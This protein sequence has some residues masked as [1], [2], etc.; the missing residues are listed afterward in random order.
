MYT[1]IEYLTVLYNNEPVKVL[2]CL[3]SLTKCL[4]NTFVETCMVHVLIEFIK[5]VMSRVEWWKAR[6]SKQLPHIH[7]LVHIHLLFHIH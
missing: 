7:L 3:C 4:I 5:S 2:S 6:W 1:V